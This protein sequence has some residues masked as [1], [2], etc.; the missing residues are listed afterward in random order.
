MFIRSFLIMNGNYAG[1]YMFSEHI[2]I[3][4]NRIDIFDWEE[5][6]EDI[7]LSDALDIGWKILSELPREEL[8]RIKPEFI[9]KYLPKED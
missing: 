7:D 8:T 5:E 6:A 4:T 3:G 9:E 2:R 1:M